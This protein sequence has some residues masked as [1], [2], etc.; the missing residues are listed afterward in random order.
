MSVGLM[1]SHPP[2]ICGGEIPVDTLLEA[3]FAAS[4]NG[5]P[6]AEVRSRELSSYPS[7][8]EN[9]TQPLHGVVIDSKTAWSGIAR[10]LECEGPVAELLQKEGPLTRPAFESKWELREVLRGGDD[11]LAYRSVANGNELTVR[12]TNEKTAL[13]FKLLARGALGYRYSL[14]D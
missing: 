2:M 12:A 6:T 11:P 8:V 1:E 10:F 9:D 4:H 13:A 7:V 3:S 14:T 5:D